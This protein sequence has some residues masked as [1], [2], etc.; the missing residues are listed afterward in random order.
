MRIILENALGQSVDTEQALDPLSDAYTGG[1]KFG[2]D[3]KDLF[4]PHWRPCDPLTRC[5]HW[6]YCG[7]APHCSRKRC[8]LATNHCMAMMEL[9]ELI[10]PP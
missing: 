7:T 2:R 8:R 10:L 4:D 6:P 9:V 3:T 5:S 1:A